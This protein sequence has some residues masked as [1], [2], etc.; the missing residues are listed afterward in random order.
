MKKIL[1]LIIYLPFWAFSQ[2][3]QAP[4]ISNMTVKVEKAIQ[5][6]TIKYDLY[7]AENDPAAMTLFFGDTSGTEMSKIT[8]AFGNIG[9]GIQPG[10]DKIITWDYPSLLGNEYLFKLTLTADDWKGG[11]ISELLD[12]VN[13]E[14]MMNDLRYLAKSPRH[15]SS[16]PVQLSA[17][18][19]TIQKILS[20]SLKN[21]TN[22][23]FQSGSIKG[24]N[25]ISNLSGKIIPTKSVVIDAH[26]DTVSSSPGA[27][28]NA[29]GV[30]AMLEAARILGKYNFKKSLIFA[31]F[32]LEEDGLLGSKSFAKNLSS[33]EIEAVI[34]FEMIGFYTDKANTQTLP[35][36]FNQLF[37]QAYNAVK[38]DSFKG[39]FITNVGSSL[40]TS[41]TNTFSTAASQ[42]VPDLKVVSI[43]VPGNGSS[44]PD[45][46]RSDHASF[47]DRSISAL[48]ITDGANFRNSQYHTS[49]DISS[50][51]NKDFLCKVTKAAI[52]TTITLAEID[53]SGKAEFIYDEKLAVKEA[54]NS[55][56]Q[57]LPNPAQSMIT[58]RF[59][60]GG[61]QKGNIILTDISGKNLLSLAIKP[62]QEEYAI[63]ISHLPDGTY[64]IEA[65]SI[66]KSFIKR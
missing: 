25:L 19:D 29:S 2:Q 4:V 36:G 41:L 13:C 12:Q 38:Q 62:D 20:T 45:L 21:S 55:D 18:R 35:A 33:K 1:F 57:I 65:G 14:R 48:M 27:D 30:V 60:S 49:S 61:L 17:S 26:Y 31:A 52:P 44:T 28:D 11:T 23:S 16:N 9:G 40:S 64:I 56:F 37:P 39:N 8:G 6:I 66:S 46:R 51:I 5:R 53:H 54:L 58:M 15:R 10:K 22:I 32:D 43:N 24:N 3:N 63:D 34:N 47:W 50:T 7:D 42:Y 59:I